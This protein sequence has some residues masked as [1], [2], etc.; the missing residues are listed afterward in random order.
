MA[1]AG[2]GD[3]LSG[4]LVGIL[5]YNEP[6]VLTVA[7]GAYLAG[8]AGE[9]AQKNLNDISMR[10]SDTISKIPEAINEIRR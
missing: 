5:G 9:L 7:G 8:L 10:A 4:I 1:T 3:V 2:S 6:N